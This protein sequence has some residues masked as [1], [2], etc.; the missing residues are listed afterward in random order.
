MG[1][2]DA[3]ATIAAGWHMSLRQV[4]ANGHTLLTAAQ[5]KK[6]TRFDQP[7]VAINYRGFDGK[8]LKD[9]TGRDRVRYRLSDPKAAGGQRYTSHSKSSADGVTH[10]RS[11]E[12]IIIDPRCTHAIEEARLYSFKT[13]RLSGDVLPDVADKHNHIWDAVRYALEPL[14][15]QPGAGILTWLTDPRYQPAAPKDEKRDKQTDK[16]VR[17]TS[18]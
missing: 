16:G 7:S 6:L 18:L 15:S 13:D 14:I 12:Q 11:Y 2:T 8:P 1:F 17:I 4:K 5:T 3:H 9:P 10:L